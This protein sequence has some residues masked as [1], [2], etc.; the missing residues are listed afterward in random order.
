MPDVRFDRYYRYD[1]LVRIL[2]G[3]AQEYP[4]LVHLESIGKSYEGRDIWLAAITDFDSG[5]D[6]YQACAVGGRQHPCQANCRP[7]VPVCT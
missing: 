2:N 4:H 3:Y 5:E 6:R 1:D 7:P